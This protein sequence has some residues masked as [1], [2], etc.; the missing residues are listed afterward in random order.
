MPDECRTDALAQLAIGKSGGAPSG[1][2]RPA[3]AK[4]PGKSYRTIVEIVYRVYEHR[5][6]IPPVDCRVTQFGLLLLSGSKIR[7]DFNRGSASSGK[8]PGIRSQREGCTLAT[9]SRKSRRQEQ[10]LETLLLNPTQRVHQLAQTLRVSAETVRRDL[11]E[12]AEGGK[13]SRTY[14]GALRT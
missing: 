6:P 13:L 8:F 11:A 3:V 14:G 5:V 4:T 1:T 9:Q 7:G 10:I 12:L 2:P